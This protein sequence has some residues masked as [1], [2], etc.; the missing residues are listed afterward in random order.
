MTRDQDELDEG[1]SAPAVGAGKVPEVHATEPGE[2]RTWEQRYRTSPAPGSP[3]YSPPTSIWALRWSLVIH[4]VIVA[5]LVLA[6]VLAV[7]GDDQLWVKVVLLLALVLLVA[8]RIFLLCNVVVALARRR[9]SASTHPPRASNGAGVGEG[10]DDAARRREA[11][12]A[13]VR[14]DLF[15]ILSNP[16]VATRPLGK[17]NIWKK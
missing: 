14:H 12:W 3:F 1:E 16:G 6:A 11:G 15:P 8:W 2:P 13:Q 9:A 7:R 10:A 17:L 5:L 4:L